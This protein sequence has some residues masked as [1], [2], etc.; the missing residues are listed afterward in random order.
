MKGK[1]GR[2]GRW[3]GSEEWTK[4][5]YGGK[6]GRGGMGVRWNAGALSVSTF[7]PFSD[8]HRHQFFR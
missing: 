8:T 7:V 3:G 2:N 5:R 1:N 6:G 4:G